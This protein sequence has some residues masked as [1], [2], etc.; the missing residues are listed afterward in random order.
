MDYETQV[1]FTKDPSYIVNAHS[2]P[3]SEMKKPAIAPNAPNGHSGVAPDQ[4]SKTPTG[5]AKQLNGMLPAILK[6]GTNPPPPATPAQAPVPAPAPGQPQNPNQAQTGSNQIQN[7]AQPAET[8]EVAVEDQNGKRKLNKK[9]RKD[10]LV[11]E[12]RK[13]INHY[14]EI[15]VRQV[16][17][18]IPKI[19]TKF[20]IN[21]I[22]ERLYFAMFKRVS[23]PAIL[24]DLKEPEHITQQ[25]TILKN[26]MEVLINSKKI[27]IKDP[28]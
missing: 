23:D 1:I 26:T 5:L 10:F 3:D 14:F 20:L 11:K 8:E 15:N 6:S 24:N 21:E 12:M 16:G 19:I 25:R 28:E 4:T 9:E 27:L 18:M 22:L 17:D 13:R 2:W 7:S